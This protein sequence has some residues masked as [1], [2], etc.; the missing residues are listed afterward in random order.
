MDFTSV[1]G[2]QPG[3]QLT[4]AH[5]TVADK[6]LVLEQNMSQRSPQ[7]TITEL[8]RAVRDFEAFSQNDRERYLQGGL[9][10]T[11]G[12]RAVSVWIAERYGDLARIARKCVPAKPKDNLADAQQRAPAWALATLLIG[13]A[14]KWRNIAGMMPDPEN[15][16]RLHQLYR[17][18]RR[19][20]IDARIQTIF[21]EQRVVEST[22][23]ALYVRALLLERFAGG[24]L[25][26][27]RLEILDNWLEAWMGAL[28]LTREPLPGVA[29]LCVNTHDPARGLTRYIP[30]ERANYYLALPPLRRQLRRTIEAFHQG[31]IFP[32]WGSGLNFRM[33]EHIAVISFLEREFHMLEIASAQK[34]KR[35][36]I[37]IHAEVSLYL[38][39]NDIFGRAL[40]AQTTLKE[41]SVEDT[42][43]NAKPDATGSFTAFNGIRGP[44]YLHNISESG[45]GLEMSVSDA[46]QIQIDD[47][48]ALQIELHRPC[49][50]GIV[51][52]KATATNRDRTQVGVKV[53]SRV[54]LRATLEEVTDRLTRSTAKAIFVAGDAEHGFAD[55]IIVPDA[56]YKA[57]P[58][59]SIVIAPH[60]YQIKLG[61]V[62]HQGAGWK[63]AA[64]EVLV[65]R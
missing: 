38:G 52:R 63:M 41:G 34:S 5:R 39:F 49:L 33:E 43:I 48:I 57:N 35:L 18:A 54:P 30:G 40:A 28:W 37:N 2:H 50:L 12:D 3:L 42:K 32:G 6:H 51:V 36:S 4:R 44:I 45:M 21:I 1:D 20:M 11:E 59:M 7:E 55:S 26:P 64:V 23:E 58:T 22:V 9:A 10:Q 15:P 65:A 56:V 13:H 19:A 31:I 60:S 24:N 14:S 46:A 16:S 25:P 61:R 8:G 53:I 47:L 17:T 62:R 29:N 27:K